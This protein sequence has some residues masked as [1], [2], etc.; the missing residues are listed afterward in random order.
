MF[1]VVSIAFGERILECSFRHK[2]NARA[3]CEDTWRDMPLEVVNEH[4]GLLVGTM[5]GTGWHETRT[6]TR[7]PVESHA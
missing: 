1:Q 2:A 4:T 3:Y 7:R 6:P 5:N